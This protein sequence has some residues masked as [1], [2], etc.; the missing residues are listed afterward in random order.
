M[1]S[2]FLIPSLLLYLLLN[3][4]DGKVVTQR[5]FLGIGLLLVLALK[6]ASFNLSDVQYNVV[7]LHA[8]TQPLSPLTNG[9]D[10]LRYACPRVNDALHQVAGVA[11]MSLVL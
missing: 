7:L 2:T 9:V 6:R 5:I 4:C 8:C 11:D 1:H 10:I 3:S